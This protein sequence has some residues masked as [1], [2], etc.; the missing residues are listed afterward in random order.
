M[1][2]LTCAEN[3]SLGTMK[4]S[5]STYNFNTA[6]HFFEVGVKSEVFD[7]FGL[8]LSPCTL[9]PHKGARHLKQ[10]HPLQLSQT[11]EQHLNTCTH[12]QIDRT[13]AGLRK[14]TKTCQKQKHHM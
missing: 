3:C 11:P 7:L 4:T 10:L 1:I 9:H 5:H 12:I 6:D 13:L 14:C 8:Q 2:V